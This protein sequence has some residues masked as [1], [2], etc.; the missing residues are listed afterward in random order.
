MVICAFL[1]LRGPVLV[2]SIYSTAAFSLFNQ[3]KSLT[4]SQSSK[5]QHVINRFR[6]A[7]RLTSKNMPAWRGLGYALL[8]SAQEEDA[9]AAWRHMP[10]MENELLDWG[11]VYEKEGA[12]DEALSWYMRTAHLFPDLGD[13]WYHIGF[14]YQT[15]AQWDKALLAYETA[16]LRP[17]FLHPFLS[18]AYFQQ[19]FIY[20]GVPQRQEL[21]TALAMYDQ[22]LASDQFSSDVVKAEAFYKRGEIY[23]WQG[24]DPALSLA[25]YRQAIALYPEHSWARLR[26]GYTIYQAEGDLATAVTEIERVILTWQES[27]SQYLKSAYI[28]L[29]EI[30]RDAGMTEEAL[31]AL[32]AAYSLDPGNTA[33]QE[34]IDG[35]SKEIK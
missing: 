31:A 12:F 10:E 17:H 27:D 20:Q 1:L 19:G 14:I 13:P 29:G 24:M 2:S 8:D 34:T 26:M 9:L 16:V 15:E 25:Q 21:E 6:L 32:T 4:T 11:V 18:D 33:I 35:L 28:Y 3:E 22:A 23:G 7:T 30:Y 5:M